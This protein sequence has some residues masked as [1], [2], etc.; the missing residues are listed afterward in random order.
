MGRHGELT[1]F[2]SIHDLHLHPG[3]LAVIGRAFY[4]AA[5]LFFGIQH[6]VYGAFV[7][8]IMP[9]WPAWVPGGPIG[10]YLTG[11]FLVVAGTALF[12]ER[13]A[14]R[15]GL[16]LGAVTLLGAML[17][18]LPTAASHVAWGGEWTFAGK[19]FALGGGALIVA[20]TL[21]TGSP[22]A[23]WLVP[24]GRVCL[25][26]FLILGGIQHF[27]WAK[28]VASLVPAWIPG[29]MFWVYFAGVALIAGG[30]GMLLPPTARLA[31]ALTALMIFL[32]VILLHIP[33]ALVAPRGANE[34]TA[35]FEALAMCGIALMLAAVPRGKREG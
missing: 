17:L 13:T 3:R 18:A 30:L 32:W 33:R 35:V 22:G 4:A 14:R 2:P 12:L 11:L 19:A 1:V 21:R 8:R 9:P 20:A 29:A 27:I 24:V 31:A 6:L 15:A 5:V 26:G 16:V 34:A 28:F 23:A 10:A 25:C 7:T